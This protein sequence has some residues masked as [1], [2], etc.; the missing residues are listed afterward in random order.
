MGGNSEVF[1]F[2]VDKHDLVVA[3]LLLDI[4]ERVAHRHVLEVTGYALR[5]CYA[6]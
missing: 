4:L 2:V 6:C 5:V 1:Q 3:C